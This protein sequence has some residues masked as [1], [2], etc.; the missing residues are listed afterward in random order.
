[1]VV[2]RNGKH[3]GEANDQEAGNATESVNLKRGE[4]PIAANKENVNLSSEV[5]NATTEGNHSKQANTKKTKLHGSKTRKG[6]IPGRQKRDEGNATDMKQAQEEHDR[7][8]QCSSNKPPAS[9]KR[10]RKDLEIEWDRSQLRD[11]RPTP[12]RVLLPRR[13]ETD[14]TEE[15]KKLFKGPPAKRPRARGRLHA[16]Q[17]DQMFREEAKRN[18][19]HTAHE[20]YVCFDKGPNGSPTYDEAGFQL[21]YR[22]VADWMKPK[23]YNKQAMVNGM[24]RALKRGEEEKSR[25]AAAFFEGGQAP[26]EGGGL[27]T[28]DLLKDKVSKD[29]GIAFHKVTPAKVEGWA[30]KGFPKENPRDYVESTLTAEERKRFLSMHMGSSLRK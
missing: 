2:L 6:L 11:P 15:E 18:I 22:K 19:A 12:E 30:K 16:C 10:T 21:D 13:S 5:D 3:S 29:L 24:E 27:G 7:K 26:D 25:M 17:E 1:M 14:L 8:D 4:A 9:R 23:M 28:L 20:L